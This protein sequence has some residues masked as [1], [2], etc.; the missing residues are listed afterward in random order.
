[1]NFIGSMNIPIEIHKTD[2][3]SPDPFLPLARD[4]IRESLN[5]PNPKFSHVTCHASKTYGVVSRRPIFDTRAS[6]SKTNRKAIIQGLSVLVSLTPELGDIIS[7][8]Q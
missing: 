6:S 3:K 1:M 2:V 5:S 7:V 4:V 8:S